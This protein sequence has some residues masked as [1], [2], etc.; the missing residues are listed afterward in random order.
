MPIPVVRE[1]PEDSSEDERQKKGR[2]MNTYQL[3]GSGLSYGKRY[4]LMSLL[5]I[6]TTEEDIDGEYALSESSPRNC[7]KQIIPTE[8]STHPAQLPS[9][10]GVSYQKVQDPSGRWIILAKG[11]TL[12][13]KDTLKS[14]GFR[15]DSAAR[16]W[17]KS[18]S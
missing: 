13:N 2:G 7:E 9:I 1:P 17:W 6:S 16:N 3:Y 8:V 4:G 10:S 18:A 15:W 14:Y 12:E 5:A 11:K